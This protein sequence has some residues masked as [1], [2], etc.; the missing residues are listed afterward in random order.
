MWLKQYF[1]AEAVPPPANLPL[2]GQKHKQDETPLACLSPHRD[3]SAEDD[4]DDTGGV[5]RRR[6]VGWTNTEDLTILAAVLVETKEGTLLTRSQ[7]SRA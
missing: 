3:A 4:E 1:V 7:P 5:K 2:V 6:K